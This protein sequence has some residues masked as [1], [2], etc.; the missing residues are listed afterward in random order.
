MNVQQTPGIVGDKRRAENAHK[1]SQHDH[2]GCVHVDFMNQ[3]PVIGFT[4][5]KRAGDERM[6]CNT[7]LAGAFKAERVGLIAENCPY[8]AFNFVGFTGVNNCL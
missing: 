4:T 1:T 8:G 2:I 3:L 6:R 7:R 5:V